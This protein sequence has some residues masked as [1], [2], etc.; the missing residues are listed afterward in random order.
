MKEILIN[1]TTR[2]WDESGIDDMINRYTEICTLFDGSFSL[3]RI[4]NEEIDEKICE[5]TEEYVRVLMV[6]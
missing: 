2:A 5:K 6:K 3:A 1:A 4:K